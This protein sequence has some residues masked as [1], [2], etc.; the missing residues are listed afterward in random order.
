[1]DWNDDGKKDLVTG[2]GDGTIRIY[3]NKGTNADPLFNGYE[4]LRMGGATFD[5][6]SSS[7]PEIVDWNNDGRKDVLCGEL[8]GR[9]FILI[10]T[11]TSADPAFDSMAYIPNGTGLIDVGASS[12]PCVAD[13][14][15]DGRKDL[16][17]G[18]SGGRVFLFLNKGTDE[19]PVFNG[20]LY[21]LAGGMILDVNSYS[22]IAKAD[23]NGDGVM[24][25][26]SGNQSYTGPPDPQG[27]VI[28]FQAAGPLSS[29]DNVL[30]ASAGG[31]IDF[32]LN[33]G[34]GNSGR[35]FILLGSIT[36]TSP[37]TPLPGGA[38]LLPLNWDAFTDLV[39]LLLNTPVFQNFLSTL[40]GSGKAQA[41]FNTF[42]P[43]P[44]A[45]GL[46]LSF[47]YALNNPWDYASNAVNVEI[48][49]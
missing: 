28:Y 41:A 39:L 3:L 11:G 17:A 26:L 49:P 30:S 7:M 48:V 25:L 45:A 29:S 6:G 21:L 36:G 1:V 8:N 35:K 27:G 38:A 23:W 37:G 40:D 34:V 14:D 13:W 16:L 20:F 44:G 2:E 33:A 43:V 24:D 4:F 18:E 31:K 22:R 42:G 10:N 46:T 47:A 19:D 15:R 9:I 12:S 5:C 32:S